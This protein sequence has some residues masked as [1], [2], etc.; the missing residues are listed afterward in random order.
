MVRMNL[1]LLAVIIS[2]VLLVFLTVKMKVHPLFSLLLSTFAFGFLAQMPFEKIL[3]AYG[4]G[5][6]GTIAD[7][8]LVIAM[9]TVI[10]ALLEKCGSAETMAKTVLKITGQKY[11]ALGLTITGYFVSI[12]VFCDSAFVILSSL[13]KRLSRDTETS[14]ATMAVALAMGLHTTHILVPPTP[15]PLAV[16]GILGA[17]LG[18]VI[19][20]SSFVAIPVLLA[21]Y[22][23]AVKFGAKYYYLPAN[24]EETITEARRYPSALAA[25]APIFTPVLLMMLKTIADSMAKISGGS[26]PLFHLLSFLGTPLIALLVGLALALATYLSVTGDKSVYTFDGE[27]GQALRVAGQIVLIVGAG[28]AFGAVLKASPLKDILTN[29][30]SGMSLGILAPFI[31]GFVFRTAIGSGTVAMITAATM[32]APIMDVFGF[33]GTIGRIIGMIAC[34]SGAFMVFHGN[35]DYFWV[36]AS[37]SEMDPAIAYKLLPLASVCQAFTSLAMAFVLSMI[38]I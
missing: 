20:I 23:V 37:A 34:A 17:D 35:D 16:T 22:L 21:G 15:G 4:K 8:G 13:A 25:F 18:M 30:F 11:A 10:G 14:M 2:I 7:I 6:G 3:E 1:T 29:T 5:L 32:L 28:G 38:F 24:V 9:G 33:V 19:V 12:P 26:N 36:V 31:I 27:F